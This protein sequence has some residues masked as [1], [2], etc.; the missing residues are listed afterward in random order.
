MSSLCASRICWAASLVRLVISAPV[1]SFQDAGL[2]EPWCLISKCDAA[3]TSPCHPPDGQASTPHA[4]AERAGT[5]H[6]R[7]PCRLAPRP[8]A[9]PA[10]RPRWAPGRPTI[11]RD[12]EIVRGRAVGDSVQDGVHGGASEGAGWGGEHRR[13]RQGSAP[14][15]AWHTGVAPACRHPSPFG[16]QH[17]DASGPVYTPLAQEWTRSLQPE[18]AQPASMRRR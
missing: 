5:A 9:H 3:T 1:S 16:T 18:H 17:A 4:L 10:A 7:A 15:R 8:A 2:R 13:A 12:F 11:E 6:T 14:A